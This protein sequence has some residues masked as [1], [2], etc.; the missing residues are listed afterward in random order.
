MPTSPIRRKFRYARASTSTTLT[1]E[2]TTKRPPKCNEV[3]DEL[4]T[5]NR[6][7]SF[8]D[9]PQAGEVRWSAKE[10]L[11]RVSQVWYHLVQTQSTDRAE[12][13]PQAQIDNPQDY[14]D[15]ARSDQTPLLTKDLML[16]GKTGGSDHAL[17]R[18]FVLQ[19]ATPL[20]LIPG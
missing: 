13:H 11:I 3:I 2:N 8:C 6:L 9:H 1:A 20:S 7:V 12:S 17:V 15:S 16:I 5:F 10:F 4:L 19:L 18:T 14:S